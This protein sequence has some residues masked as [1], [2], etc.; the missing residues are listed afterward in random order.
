[1]EKGSIYSI[2]ISPERG[3]VK[4]EIM[5]VLI[6]QYGIEND[7]HAGKWG[8]QIT[9]L[10]W[11]SVLIANKENHLQ[12]GPGEF[13]ENILIDG[14]D[15]SHMVVGDRL[16][17]GDNVILEVYQIGKED[18]PSVVTRTLGI[19]LLPYEGLFCKVVQGGTLEKGDPVEQII[20]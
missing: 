3:Q 10:N 11:G 15:L 5:E 4:E 14:L 1:M 7:G 13:A 9:C 20:I 19:S 8:R 6:T 17:M 2:C 16:K 12:V 18:H